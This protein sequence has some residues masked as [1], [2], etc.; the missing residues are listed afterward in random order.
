ME[1]IKTKNV[2]NY[3]GGEFV[4]FDEE[5]RG[6]GVFDEAMVATA[7][8][9]SH[10]PEVSYPNDRE[11]VAQR[12]EQFEQSVRWGEQHL[13]PV[14]EYSVYAN[15]ADWLDVR[16]EYEVRANLMS[17]YD[18]IANGADIMV[19][20]TKP[21]GRRV[22]FAID[23]TYNQ[24]KIA[25]KLARKSGYRGGLAVGMTAVKYPD[26]VNL[27]EAKG[28]V[29]MPRFVVGLEKENAVDLAKDLYEQQE[30]YRLPQGEEAYVL[31]VRKNM[32]E[33]MS[34]QVVGMLAALPEDADEKTR[35]DLK[36]LDS[37]IRAA[38]VRTLRLME[39]YDKKEEGGIK[40]GAIHSDF[41]NRVLVETGRLYGEHPKK[42]E[43]L[44]R[45]RME[46]LKKKA[47]QAA[48]VGVV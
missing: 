13:G 41:H 20:I 18:D 25:Q 21:D 31:A 36:F 7:H 27:P 3:G 39:K 44:A 11:Y 17:E 19:T 15:V 16:G 46:D 9:M 45:R 26:K 32:I 2:E 47:A 30:G 48:M 37:Y 29:V 34:E 28:T 23:T 4:G 33:E 5:R 43:A 35:E 22:P 38:F 8:A 24:E 14:L 12:K 40:T 1:K 10:R 42:A 6:G